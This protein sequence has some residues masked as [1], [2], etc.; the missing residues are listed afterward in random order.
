MKR[1]VTFDKLTGLV[2]VFLA[3]GW[4]VTGCASNQPGSQTSKNPQPRID[5][6]DLSLVAEAA[7]NSLLASG[8]LDRTTHHPSLLGIG[9]YLNNTAQC[10]DSEVLTRKI[11]VTLIKMG[12]V[13]VVQSKQNTNDTVFE[14]T[15]D[16]ILSGKVTQ[17]IQSTGS[18][19]Q[20]AFV[21]QFS[22]SD[23]NH[24]IVWAENKE[25]TKTTRRNLGL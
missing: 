16:F 10:F 12:K 24:Q 18:K 6:Q 7:V 14:P 4:L 23:S 9:R 15:P 1:Y 8:I 5:A 2:W 22:L 13:V 11:S 25:I 20:S 3:A 17:M 19:G 21:F